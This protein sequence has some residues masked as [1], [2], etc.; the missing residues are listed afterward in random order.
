MYFTRDCLPSACSPSQESIYILLY[1]KA[2]ATMIYELSLNEIQ[3]QRHELSSMRNV[4][5]QQ[6][7]AISAVISSWYISKC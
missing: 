5:E 1:M 7:D 3:T 4:Q 2:T 6:S